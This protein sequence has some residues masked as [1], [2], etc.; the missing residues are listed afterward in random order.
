MHLGG[1][2]GRGRIARE[3]SSLQNCGAAGSKTECRSPMSRATKWPTTSIRVRVL[4]KRLDQAMR[5]R[6]GRAA[7]DALGGVHF[8]DN[9]AVQNSYP[10]PQRGD[11]QQ[12][13]RNLKPRPS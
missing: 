2:A 10:V 7:E 8:H 9:A 4:G 6:M 5:V 13:L 1:Q 3:T 11:G 12:A